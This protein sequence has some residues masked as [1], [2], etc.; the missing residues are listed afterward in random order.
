MK[1]LYI[2]LQNFIHP[3]AH[4][5]VVLLFS[6]FHLGRGHLGLSM[7]AKL[8]HLMEQRAAD[9][10]YSTSFTLLCMLSSKIEKCFLLFAVVIL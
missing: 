4:D 3:F 8:Y 2:A 1:F 9:W 5:L 6:Q 10:Y 7:K